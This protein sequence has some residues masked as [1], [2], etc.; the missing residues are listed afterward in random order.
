LTG[1]KAFV[2]GA[3]QV[4]GHAMVYLAADESHF[5]TGATIKRDGGIS[6][7]EGSADERPF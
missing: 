3:V 1:K 2:P 5:M 4:I 6:A 7:M